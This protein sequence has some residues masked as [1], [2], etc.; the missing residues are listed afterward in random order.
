MLE[1]ILANDN[2]PYMVCATVVVMLG[3]IEAMAR[4]AG[5]SLGMLMDEPL[6]LQS[7]GVD[8]G[9]EPSLASWLGLDRLPVFLWFI[10]ALISFAIGGFLL[11]LLT[12]LSFNI[13]LPQEISVWPAFALTSVSCHLLGKQLAWKRGED[14]DADN[15][16]GN[17]GIL[18]LGK[19]IKG[20]PAEALVHDDQQRIH[21]VMV[22]PQEEDVAF[23]AGTRVLLLQKDGVIWR[24]IPFES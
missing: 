22:E 11:N 7:S 5:G 23:E 15:L 21:Y 4:L 17:I 1:F 6:A 8:I 2:L 18:T 13:L 9:E 3:V 24:A 16:C 14:E 12:W 20:N 10:L 19:A